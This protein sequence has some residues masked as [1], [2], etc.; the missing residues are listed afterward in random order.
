[1]DLPLPAHPLNDANDD[2]DEAPVE[3]TSLAGLWE[4]WDKDENVRRFALMNGTLL[5][6]PSPK[7]TGVINFGTMDR[8]TRVL[9]YVME[10]WVP[11]VSTAKTIHIDH[12]RD[13]VRLP[14]KKV[15]QNLVLK[16]FDTLYAN[17]LYGCVLGCSSKHLPRTQF[18]S[19]CDQV[20]TF[21]SKQG[22]EDDEV[23][24]NCDA[25]S[26]RGFVTYL[27]RRHNG[28]NRRDF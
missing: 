17:L 14:T 12:I 4:K 26:I 18:D 21:R 13:E 1:M 5:P 7:H 6:W 2:V 28:S 11:Q 27:V 9:S 20:R 16:Y 3:G 23:K 22:W 8:N 19:Y 10:I 25:V 15:L 24:V